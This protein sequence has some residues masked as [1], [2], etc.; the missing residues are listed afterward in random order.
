MPLPSLGTFSSMNQ[1]TQAPGVRLDP[2]M[3]FNF[4]VEIGG[5]VGGGFTTVSGLESSVELESYQEG[6]VNG[7]VHQIPGQVTYPNL[8]LTQGLTNLS[9]LWDWYWLTTQGRPL[10]LNGTI[11]L[12]NSQRL[13]VMWWNF[14][15]AYPVKWVG[16]NL[17]ASNDSQVAIE[18]LE[19][20]H[21]GIAK[22]LSGAGI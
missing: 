4:L 7:Y 15:D 13:P 10:L 6:G 9:L 16:P 12:L 14:Q 21:R 19:L 17:D 22:T 3:G 11:M 2:Y 5:M 1:L 20:V 18:Q 8:V